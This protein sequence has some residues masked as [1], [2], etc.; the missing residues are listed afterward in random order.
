MA[1]EAILLKGDKV[2][3][4]EKVVSQL[5][6]WGEVLHQDLSRLYHQDSQSVE[7]M[8]PLVVFRPY[9]AEEI[10]HAIRLCGELAL[11]L[12][13]RC[14][15]TGLYGG[16]LAA[17]GGVVLLTG[18]LNQ[19]YRE[20]ASRVRSMAG[21]S[22]F[23]MNRAM[24]P[25]GLWFPFGGEEEGAAGMAGLLMGRAFL[26]QH[27]QG[28]P[29]LEKIIEVEMWDG[30]GQL[31]RVHPK[32]VV[33]SEG[34][35][36]VV[37]SLLLKLSPLPQV[38][39]WFEVQGELEP[40]KLAQLKARCAMRAMVWRGGERFWFWVCGEKPRSEPLV[41]DVLEELSGK[42]VEAPPSFPPMAC[43]SQWIRFTSTLSWTL[44]DNWEPLLLQLVEDCQLHIHWSYHYDR[45]ELE[46]V[47]FSHHSPQAFQEQVQHLMVK[48]VNLL[49]GWKGALL[50]RGASGTLLAPY[51]PAFYGESTLSYLYSL[52][53]K[54]DPHGIFAPR[55]FFP[56]EGKCVQQVD[57]WLEK[58]RGEEDGCGERASRSP[59]IDC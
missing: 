6:R 11:P 50:G 28:R 9:G 23:V 7:R 55:N 19:F 12:T 44:K 38:S 59:D 26:D 17:Q 47:L 57:P 22:P 40:T 58:M 56:Q 45:G 54:W 8:P 10:P 35:L 14:G 4:Y 39:Q 42:K 21:A 2:E 1:T 15:G 18:H 51:M 29:L 5:S 36:G 13:A 31:H 20:G 48:W 52:K 3:H 49:A 37:R 27:Y 32:E 16:A 34:V 33:A 30:E 24:A 41:A 46:M 53:R 25:S 43:G